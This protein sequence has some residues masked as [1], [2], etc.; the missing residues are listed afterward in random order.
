[1]TLVPPREHLYGS[2]SPGEWHVNGH[3]NQHPCQVA[4]SCSTPLHTL[5]GGKGS[6]CSSVWQALPV[7]GLS[8]VACTATIR[9]YGPL[10][11]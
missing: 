11:A 10:V 8:S 3:R 1:M 4:A 5:S 9:S 7:Q 6:T 2:L